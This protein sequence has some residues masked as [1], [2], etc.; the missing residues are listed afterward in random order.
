MLTCKSL[1]KWKNHE[2]ERKLNYGFRHVF[3]PT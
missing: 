1:E 2:A 3:V